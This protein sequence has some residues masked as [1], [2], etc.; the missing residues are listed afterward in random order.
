MKTGDNEETLRFAVHCIYYDK[1][2]GVHHMW[3]K[4]VQN[5]ILNKCPYLLDVN[6]YVCGSS[7]SYEKL[8]KTFYIHIP[9]KNMVDKSLH[10]TQCINLDSLSP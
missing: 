10:F 3:D 1:C 4:N 9:K 8:S 7:I 6:P 2:F 5:K